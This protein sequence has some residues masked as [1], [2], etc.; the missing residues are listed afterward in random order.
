MSVLSPTQ[1]VD[2]LRLE[3]GVDVVDVGGVSNSRSA[4]KFGRTSGGPSGRLWDRR[5]CW[6]CDVLGVD[7]L[8]RLWLRY[9]LSAPLRAVEIGFDPSMFADGRW[10]PL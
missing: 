1:A 8:G 5:A 2:L 4:A 7:S 10:E 3:L 6:S 9:E